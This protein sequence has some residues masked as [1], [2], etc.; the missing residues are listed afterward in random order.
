M[1][2]SVCAYTC[3][4]VRTCVCLC[5]YQCVWFDTQRCVSVCV[6]FFLGTRCTVP[7]RTYG[8]SYGWER[9][10]MLR[11]SNVQRRVAG[12]NPWSGSN[13][14]TAVMAPLD[15][16]LLKMYLSH[17]DNAPPPPPHPPP[18][19]LLCQNGLTVRDREIMVVMESGQRWTWE[20]QFQQRELMSRTVIL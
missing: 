3:V 14:L 12:G 11:T 7:V 19:P 13:S 9:R 8:W 20:I 2:S 5:Q 15:L 18:V 10:P 1:C 16:F 6:G 17:P 4:Y